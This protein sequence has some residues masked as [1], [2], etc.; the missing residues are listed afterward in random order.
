M[1]NMQK[2]ELLFYVLVPVYKTEAYLRECIDSVLKQTYQNF[3]LVLVDDGSPDH[4]GAICEE[5]ASQDSRITVIHKQN[6]GLLAARQTAVDWVKKEIRDSGSAE[7]RYVVFL[8]SDDTLKPFALERICL[9]IR[10][11]G[12]DMVIYGYDRVFE[13]K[14]IKPYDAEKAFGGIVTDK[15]VLYRTVFSDQKYNSLCRK[16]VAASLITDMDYT[17]FYGIVR[18]EDLFRSME[19]LGGCRKVYFLQE[20]LYNYTTN[21]LSI[22]YSETAASCDTGFLLHRCVYEFLEKENVFTQAD[23][24][25]YQAQCIEMVNTTILRIVRSSASV[26]EKMNLLQKVRE[27]EY[28]RSR[29]VGKKYNRRELGTAHF[30]VHKMFVMKLDRLLIHVYAA[31]NKLWRMKRKV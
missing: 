6:Q 21:P 14:I 31:Y 3:Q 24:A 1:Q 4:S 16:A 10:K 17:P 23:W 22:T 15:R 7:N 12:C 9:T 19:Y 18:G 8:D 5:Y 20:S 11:Y 26:T 27:S 30:L 29:I 25:D 2:N 13:G 28:Y